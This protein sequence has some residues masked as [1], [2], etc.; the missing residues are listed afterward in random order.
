[1]PHISDEEPLNI[2]SGKVSIIDLPYRLD[3]LPRDESTGCHQ[4]ENTHN[5]ENCW[6][7]I[8]S[9]KSGNKT[10]M[11]RGTTVLD[12]QFRGCGSKDRDRSAREATTQWIEARSVHERPR[13]NEIRARSVQ[14]RTRPN[15]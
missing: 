10:L 15:V 8:H 3:L 12:K 5:T 13:L 6:T 14:E 4:E 1:M 2:C 11:P 7:F 9:E